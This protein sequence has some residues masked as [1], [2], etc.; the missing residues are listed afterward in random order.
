MKPK[1]A[2]SCWFDTMTGKS[3]RKTGTERE[4]ERD[5]GEQH[6]EVCFWPVLS[7][8]FPPA[9]VSAGPQRLTAAP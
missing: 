3:L 7:R 4:R 2:R 8:R 9:G 5:K 6:R 1:L